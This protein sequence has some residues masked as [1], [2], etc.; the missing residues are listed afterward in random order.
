MVAAFA[1][2]GWTI[3]ET[4][5]DAEDQEWEY[6]IVKAGR[7]VELKIEPQDADEGTGTELSITAK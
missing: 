3:V 4:K 7:Q 5:Q 1:P 6:T 2:N